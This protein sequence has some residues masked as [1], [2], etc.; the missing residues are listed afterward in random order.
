MSVTPP[1]YLILSHSNHLFLLLPYGMSTCVLVVGGVGCSGWGSAYEGPTIRNSERFVPA[2]EVF[3]TCR[4][5]CRHL[6]LSTEFY[7]NTDVDAKCGSIVVVSSECS[8]LVQVIL[9]L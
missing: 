8:T 5:G 3:G 4:Q 2:Y 6:C 7:I 1:I 9:S